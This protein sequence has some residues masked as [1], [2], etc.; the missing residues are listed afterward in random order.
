MFPQK[1]K[2]WSE[3]EAAQYIEEEIKVFVRTSP[4]N[5]I[6]TMDNQTIYDEPLVQ[7]ADSADP[8]FAEYKTYV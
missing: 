3:T 2:G 6:P 1:A 7:V 8:L 4:R 5:Q